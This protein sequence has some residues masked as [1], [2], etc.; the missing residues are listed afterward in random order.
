[1]G[2]DTS[3][4]EQGRHGFTHFE[5]SLVELVEQHHAMVE[6]PATHRA[7]NVENLPEVVARHFFER[8]VGAIHAW[9]GVDE[10]SLHGEHGGAGVG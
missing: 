4:V 10:G 1:M 7:T 8:A 2:G 3:L 5:V 6:G 9:R